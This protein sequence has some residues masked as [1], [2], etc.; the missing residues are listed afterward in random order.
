M[1]G[2][3]SDISWSLHLGNLQSSSQM[4]ILGKSRL[5]SEWRMNE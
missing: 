4:T 2:T 5:G 3:I 1:S